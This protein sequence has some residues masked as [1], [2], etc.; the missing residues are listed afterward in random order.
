MTETETKSRFNKLLEAMLTRP[1]LSGTHGP[2]A[3]RDEA[4]EDARLD[5]CGEFQDEDGTWKVG[6]HVVEARQDPLRLADWI[7]VERMLECAEDQLAESDR[8]SYEHDDGPWFEATKEQEADIV[9]RIERACDEWQAA[10]GLVFTCR[11]FSASRNHESV[12]VPHPNDDGD[13]A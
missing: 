7:D 11:T 5:A 12:V 9:K 8:V 1:P 10:H 13:A 4:I 2:C 6:V 3:T